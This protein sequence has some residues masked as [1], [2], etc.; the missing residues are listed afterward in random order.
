MHNQRVQ[1][2]IRDL[3]SWIAASEPTFHCRMGASP[4]A[5]YS[6][7]P[8]LYRAVG[9]IANEQ[10]LTV[11]THWAESPE[12]LQLFETG[13]GPMRVFLEELNAWDPDWSGDQLV[14]FSQVTEW[15][16][17]EEVLL[18]HMNYPSPVTFESRDS[19][20]HK[21]AMK[22]PEGYVLDRLQKSSKGVVYCPRTH[23][24]FGHSQHAYRDMM[25]SNIRVSLGTDS[26]A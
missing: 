26:L 10:E 24:Y 16:A 1:E 12:E 19:C 4:H 2:S 25:P 14:R 11:C 20:H 5:P 23:A 18:V 22:D 13:T 15:M 17:A 7:S 3:R 9:E 6:A 21:S 8:D